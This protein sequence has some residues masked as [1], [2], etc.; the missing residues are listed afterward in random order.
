MTDMT[1]QELERL[2]KA[3]L[4]ALVKERIDPNELCDFAFD[5]DTEALTIQELVRAYLDWRTAERDLQQ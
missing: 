2:T 3:E 1:D 5:N 4:I